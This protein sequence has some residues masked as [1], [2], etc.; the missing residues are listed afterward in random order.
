VRRALRVLGGARTPGLNGERCQEVLAALGLDLTLLGNLL[1]GLFGEGTLSLVAARAAHHGRTAPAAAT[2]ASSRLEPASSA[3]VGPRARPAAVRTLPEPPATSAPVFSFRTRMQRPTSQERSFEE[4]TARREPLAN[5]E[6]D[7]LG[8]MHARRRLATDA[9]S[10]V[11][12]TPSLGGASGG[13]SSVDSSGAAGAGASRAGDAAGARGW[14]GGLSHAPV[15][16]GP[17]GDDFS[18]GPLAHAAADVTLRE[19]LEQYQ[20]RASQGEVSRARAPRVSGGHASGRAALSASTAEVT[21][22]ARLDASPAELAAGIDSSGSLADAAARTGLSANAY[23]VAGPAGLD[24]SVAELAER[25]G[26]SG[27]L[28]QVAG[29][30]GLDASVAEAAGPLAWDAS[31][32]EV[33]GYAG[34]GSSLAEAAARAGLSGSLAQVAGRAGLDASRAD[35]ESGAMLAWWSTPTSASNLTADLVAELVNDSLLEQ[36][37][38]HGLDLR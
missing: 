37:R 17:L 38:L 26:L 11:W 18:A 21:G 20:G 5:P 32:A 34:L 15:R 10:S 30:A 36:A 7:A 28:A 3:E 16:H 35:P 29:R 12:N 22:H 27:S 31:L 9:E 1:R 19:L 13:V 6:T 33:A 14:A 23:E 4:P 8:R 2:R 25:A 24:G